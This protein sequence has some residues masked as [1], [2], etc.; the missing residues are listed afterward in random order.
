MKTKRPLLF[1]FHPCPSFP[2]SLSSL[3]RFIIQ[4]NKEFQE[5]QE[6]DVALLLLGRLGAPARLFLTPTRMLFWDK[7]FSCN[8]KK[9]LIYFNFVHGWVPVGPVP[10]YVNTSHDAR[11][12]QRNNTTDHHVLHILFRDC[13]LLP[14]PK[15][16]SECSYSK[17]MVSSISN[18]I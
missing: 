16:T 3:Q 11:G 14:T 18:F 9:G 4:P 13:R 10:K 8:I 7:M 1:P 6:G 17:K 12:A 2:F 5:V 15:Y